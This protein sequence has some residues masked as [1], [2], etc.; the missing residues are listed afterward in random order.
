MKQSEYD[1]IRSEMYDIAMSDPHP[2]FED[3]TAMSRILN[4]QLG[5]RIIGI[6]EGG[7]WHICETIAK[8]VGPI[9]R[10]LV[11]DPSRDQLDNLRKKA[12]LSQIETLVI[13]AEGLN[14]ESESFDKV[15]SFGAFHHI[16][17]QTQAMK[18]IYNVLVPGGK[19][20]ICDVFQGS[21]LARHFDSVVAR[22]CVTGHEVK[23]LSQEFAKSLCYLAGFDD[24]KVRIIEMPQ[25]WRFNSEENLGKFIYNLHAM[26]ELD[27]TED[28]KIKQT[29]EGCRDIL[30]VNYNGEKYELNWP[31]KA[32]VAEKLCSFY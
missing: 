11:T 20:V 23:F 24:D 13:G 6:G 28:E 1:G 22:Y 17:N 31:M 21:D 14:V 29:I 5:E 12:N 8:S 9:G 18:N 30:G 32:L 19:A 3:T 16:S 15:W 7:N 25:K 26:T 27:G 2:R 4:P 10:Y